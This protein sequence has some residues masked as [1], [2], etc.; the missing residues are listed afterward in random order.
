[1]RASTELFQHGRSAHVRIL[2]PILE[3]IR[4]TH[5]V[6][7]MCEV[8]PDKSLRLQTLELYV[9]ERVAT[10]LAVPGNNHATTKLMKSGSSLH[11]PIPAQLRAALGWER[12]EPLV[13]ESQDDQSVRIQ[14]LERYL[15]EKIDEAR[16]ESTAV[17]AEARL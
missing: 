2:K 3:C 10:G 1:M 7:L 12:R 9:R 5:R 8:S 15:Q 14:T 6:D 16:Q 17:A 13:M 11:A 4:W